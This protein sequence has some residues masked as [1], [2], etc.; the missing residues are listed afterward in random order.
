MADEIRKHN[1]DIEVELI[2][3]GG[4][5]FEVCLDGKLV[6]SKLSAGRFPETEEILE[7]LDS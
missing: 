3:G 2:K 7:I 6:F 4:G 5:A 1:S